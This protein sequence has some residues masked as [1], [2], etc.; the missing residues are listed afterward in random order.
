[1]RVCVRQRCEL[2]S[3]RACVRG[4]ESLIESA[5]Q[6][7]GRA[8]ILP[9]SA[10]LLSLR[11]SV[12]SSLLTL[13]TLLTGTLSTSDLGLLSSLS[14]TLSLL[15]LV[16]L[17]VSR[18]IVVLLVVLLLLVVALLLLLLLL[19]VRILLLLLVLRVPAVGLAGSTVT[20]SLRLLLLR[21]AW[22]TERRRCG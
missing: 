8:I 21:G 5:V 9:A 11:T 1:M 13:L 6:V 18:L 20:L 3:E 12:T 17:V 10:L 16:V 19:Q 2:A 22:T 15:V 7:L 14:L 4:C